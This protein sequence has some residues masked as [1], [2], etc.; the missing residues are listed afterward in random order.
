MVTYWVNQSQQNQRKLRNIGSQQPDT[1][2]LPYYTKDG[3]DWSQDDTGNFS[4]WDAPN[5]LAIDNKQNR[6]GIS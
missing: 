3:Q 4:I 1:A 6:L 2:P 5:S